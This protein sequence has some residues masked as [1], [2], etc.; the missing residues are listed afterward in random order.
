MASHIASP[1]D[2]GQDFESIDFESA[3]A[4]IAPHLVRTPL[5]SLPCDDRRIDLRGKME[6]R[7]VTGS[8]KAR[9]ACNNIACLSDEERVLGVVA[10]SSG[11]HGRALAWAARVAGVPA[12]IVMPKNA[13]PNKIEACRAEGAEVVLAKD[14]IDAD[15]VTVRCAEEGR[16][17]IHPYDRL[18][19]IEGAGTVGLELAQDWPEVE[20]VL[21]CVG[22]GG[23]SS[24]SSLALRRAL[25]DVIHIYG[26]EP[27]GSPSMRDGLAAQ[28]PVVIE[29]ISTEVQGL[30][31]PASGALNIAICSRTLNGVLTPDDAT[32]FAAQRRLVNSEEG[33]FAEVVEP[34]GACA[35]SAVTAGLLPDHLL[36][37][38]SAENPLRV[39]VTISGGNPDPV[40]LAAMRSGQE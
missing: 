17:L 9:G 30:C 21:I 25:G 18:G 24:G 16:A 4:R 15:V 26:V 40:Q 32:I 6:N 33:W 20:V 28:E 14:R 37:G 13:Y 23:L 39:A 5:L 3:A 2:F 38:R 11:N 27:I 34:A 19:T 8:F 7:Q 35:Y 29:E 12:T 10:S 36:A 1:E 31:P 22:G